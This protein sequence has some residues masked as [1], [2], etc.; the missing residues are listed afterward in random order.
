MITVARLLHPTSDCKLQLQIFVFRA[1]V[2]YREQ[3]HRHY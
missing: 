2:L 3:T 1:L